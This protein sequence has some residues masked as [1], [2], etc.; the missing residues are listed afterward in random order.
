HERS[1]RHSDALVHLSKRQALVRRGGGHGSRPPSKLRVPFEGCGGIHSWRD[2]LTNLPA[3]TI[4]AEPL[5]R[6]PSK[7]LTIESEGLFAIVLGRPSPNQPAPAA[8]CNILQPQRAARSSGTFIVS[9][10][11]RKS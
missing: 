7:P 4:R 8:P 3:P 11:L 9:S 6:S 5:P 1:E 2:R 10:Q